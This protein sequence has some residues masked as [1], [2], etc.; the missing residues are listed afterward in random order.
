[1]GTKDCR[2]SQV[3]TLIELLV[4]IAIIAIL[5]A[6]L[7]PALSKARE[8]AKNIACM[9]QLKQMGYAIEGYYQD[10]E[11]YI[12]Y[13][14]DQSGDPFGGYATVNNWAWY[15]RIAPYVGYKAKNFYQLE[16]AYKE[17]LFT[18]PAKETGAGRISCYSANMYVA[19]NCPTSSAMPN[20]VL[21]KNPKI[22]QVKGPG[23][24]V[25]IIDAHRDQQ[26]FNVAGVGNIVTRHS[27]SNN[28]LYFDGSAK[29]IEYGRML[30]YSPRA[31][32]YAF[33]AYSST[34]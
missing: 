6:M 11:E 4:V 27:G 28:A 19:R 15:C 31:W 22:M 7:L 9:N 26:F 17:K 33:G 23:S 32:G 24:K 13:G 18:C 14:W 5:A 8:K 25:F 3:F 30:F 29:W 21:L 34:Y 1:M 2:K 12:P 10:F 20:G 16:D